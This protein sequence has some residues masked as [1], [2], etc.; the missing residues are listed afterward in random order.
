METETATDAA[1]ARQ[2][3][4]GKLPERIPFDAMVEEKEAE[5]NGSGIASYNPEASWNHFSCVAL[6]LGL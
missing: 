5:P 1:A 2:A 6:D 4:F 3:R